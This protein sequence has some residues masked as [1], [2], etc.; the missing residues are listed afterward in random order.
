MARIDNLTNFLTDV[1]SAI[2]TKKG[3]QTNIPASSFDTEILSLPSGGTYEQKTMTITQNGQTTLTPSAGYDAMDQVVLTINVPIGRLQPKT[4]SI[5]SNGSITVLPD[6]GYDGFSEVSLNVNVPTIDTSDATATD[7]DLIEGTTA[8]VNGEK[9]EGTLELTDAISIDNSTNTDTS[10]TLMDLGNIPSMII[11]ADIT[12][13]YGAKQAVED[14]STLE[15]IVSQ[16][17]MANDINLTAEKIVS[18]NTILDIEGT[19]GG[20]NNQN[21]TITQNGTYTADS[22]YTGLGEVTVNVPSG[23][24]DVK[25]FET[26][27]EMQADPNPQEGDLAV[28][29]REETQPATESSTF[30]K[31]IFPNTVT[32]DEAFDDYN[33]GEYNA[34]DPVSGDFNASC[35]LSSSSFTFN[36]SGDAIGTIN[37]EY[38]SSDGITYTR[39]DGGTELQEF[40]TTIARDA[41]SDQWVDAIGEFIQLEGDNYFEGLYEATSSGNTITYQLA[42]TQL[43]ATSSYVY[44]KTFYGQNGIGNGTLTTNVSNSFADI[45]A[46]VVYKIQQQYENMTPRVLTDNDKTINKN[47]YFIPAKK[48]GTPL[49]DTSSVTGMTSLFERCVNL[50]TIP[51]LDTSAA[52]YMGMMFYG[53][54]NLVTIPLLDTSDVISITHMFERCTNLVSIP[55]LN[56]SQ[57]SYMD[58]VFLNCTSLVTIPVLDT[59]SATNMDGMFSGCSSLSNDS[60][61]N[62]LQMCINATNVTSNK[63]LRYVGLTSTQATTCQ[64]LSNYS[65][66][67]A[68]GWTTGY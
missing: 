53:C 45:N 68:A 24:G 38:E 36:G 15:I 44:G 1:A 40:G 57:V 20:I 43:D 66:F 41:W 18:G 32:L 11:D 13:F 56:T 47:I 48:D 26:I 10:I 17:Q 16:A 9:I 39:T 65:A 64:S 67:T 35:E 58:K 19:G 55:S 3:S 49:L 46:E 5:T 37:I 51:L 42:S 21:K 22:G 59:S 63:T 50:V 23:S 25:L 29:Y 12:D 7:E 27:A 52:R 62:I 14:G 34:V 54:T 33:S 28:V 6:T 4:M 60:L 61:N 31:C 2:K 8:Y 30:D